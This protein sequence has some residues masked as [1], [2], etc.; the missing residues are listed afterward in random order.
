VNVQDG[1]FNVV[2]SDPVLSFGTDTKNILYY[3]DGKDSISALQGTNLVLIKI[4]S[5]Q[6]SGSSITGG[7]IQIDSQTGTYGGIGLGVLIAVGLLVY[8]MFLRKDGPSE[9]EKEFLELLEK[10]DSSIKSKDKE[11]SIQIYN[12]IKEKY[13]LLDK[14]EKK[15]FYEIVAGIHRKISEL[16]KNNGGENGKF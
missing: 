10:I 13:K 15:T 14:K 8:F 4:P 6:T 2:Q 3:V 9:K 16:G 12:V 7:V 11:K 1:S 5:T